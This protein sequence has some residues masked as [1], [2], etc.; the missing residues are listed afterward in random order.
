MVVVKGAAEYRKNSQGEDDDKERS[1][2]KAKEK[3]KEEEKR[4]A[5]GEEGDLPKETTALEAE[6]TGCCSIS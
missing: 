3:E 5:A 2:G 4:R 6:G 1:E